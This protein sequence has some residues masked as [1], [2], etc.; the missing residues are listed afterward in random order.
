MSLHEYF[1]SLAAESSFRCSVLQNL[2][3]HCE[4]GAKGRASFPTSTDVSIS[5]FA[6]LRVSKCV[7]VAAQFFEVDLPE[8]L[9]RKMK[10]V[11][12]VL[13]DKQKVSP[14]V[15]HCFLV[16]QALN[17]R[18]PCCDAAVTH[19]RLIRVAVL[20]LLHCLCDVS[21]PAV[22]L[23]SAKLSISRISAFLA[24]FLNL[25]MLHRQYPRP[26]FVPTDLADLGAL[27]RNLAAAGFDAARPALFTCEGIFCYLPQ[28]STRA[29]PF[30]YACMRVCTCNACGKLTVKLSVAMAHMSGRVA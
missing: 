6:A 20:W 11:D 13:P 15:L 21:F 29:N 28:V 10:M 4:F 19:C 1:A 27:A 3:E 16:T 5:D 24:P 22:E 14:A 17:F 18:H 12:A 8:V 30:G 26:A 25:G 23:V 2:S 7:C 9:E